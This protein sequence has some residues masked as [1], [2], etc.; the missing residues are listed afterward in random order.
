LRGF[1]AHE[2]TQ[3]E[4]GWK[5]ILRPV[6]KQPLYSKSQG[7]EGHFDYADKDLGGGMEQNA[8]NDAQQE[9]SFLRHFRFTAMA[10]IMRMR[11]LA[12]RC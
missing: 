11:K 7:D 2:T 12:M 10:K 5:T 8:H 3:E 1:F 4:D 6:I 9:H